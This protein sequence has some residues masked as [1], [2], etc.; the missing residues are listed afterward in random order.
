[1]FGGVGRE[2]GD[3]ALVWSMLAS[4]FVRLTVEIGVKLWH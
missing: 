4:L 2:A 1:M 3:E